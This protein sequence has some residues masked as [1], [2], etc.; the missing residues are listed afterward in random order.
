MRCP[1]FR[2]SSCFN[3][4]PSFFPWGLETTRAPMLGH[5]RS[6]CRF[7]PGWDWRRAAHTWLLL[8]LTQATYIYMKA[9]YLSMFGEEEYKPF[10][11]NEVELFRWVSPSCSHC[12]GRYGQTSQAILSCGH[13]GGRSGVTPCPHP[14]TDPPACPPLPLPPHAAATGGWSPLNF[15]RGFLSQKWFCQYHL[16]PS[17]FHVGS[18]TDM[19]TKVQG[20]KVFHSAELT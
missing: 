12:V 20:G 8:C 7:Q 5:V 4:L 11:D 1:G 16:P 9:A 19:A 10:G 15:F 14:R 2:S 17:L 18:R 13:C 6:V 3:F